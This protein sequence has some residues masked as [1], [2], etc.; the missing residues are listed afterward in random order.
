M[1][2]RLPSVP[3]LV[4]A[5]VLILPTSGIAAGSSHRQAIPEYG[6]LVSAIGGGLQSTKGIYS[7]IGPD[8]LA[9]TEALSGPE[10]VQRIGVQLVAEALG[11]PKKPWPRNRRAYT[12]QDRR[13]VPDFVQGRSFVHVETGKQ[14]DLT[15]EIRD[16]QAIARRQGRELVLVT[17]KKTSLSPALVRAVS[18]S[19]QTRAGRLRVVRCI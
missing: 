19:S 18:R 1:R 12:H 4:V 2:P 7:C 5:A 6:V 13:R 17:R 3:V 11:T 10:E 9:I 16:L 8:L 14:L 15:A